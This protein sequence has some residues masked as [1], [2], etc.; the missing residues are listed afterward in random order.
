MQA[1]TSFRLLL[2]FLW[3]A[4]LAG[5]GETPERPSV[6]TGVAAE[7]ARAA[8]LA[9]AGQHLAAADLYRQLAA[10]TQT[11]QQRADFLLA[12]AEASRAGGDWDGTRSTLEQLAQMGLGGRQE[13]ER[14]MLQAEVLLQERRPGD[15]LATLG[16]PPAPGTPVDLQ[17]RYHQDVAAAYR[18]MG[19]LLET[20][21][22]LQ[23]VDALQT[24]P[25]QRLETQTEI[26]RTLALLNELVLSN[27]Q[28][29]P[30]DIG[31]GWM[32]LALLVKKYGSDPDEL[33]PLLAEWRQ[34][35]PQHPA[36]PALLD[37]YQQ[38]LQRQLQH[39]ARIGVLLP[40]SG[41]YAEVAA[42]I[43]DGIVISRFQ[44]APERRPALK[45]YDA[46]DPAGIWPLYNQAVADGAELVI[47]P[48]Q[49]EA[50]AQLVRAGELP[51]PVLAL[52]QVDAGGAPPA[53]LYMYSLSPEDEARQA[54]ERAWTDGSRR[55]VI[56]APQG[57]WGD[58]LV[59]AFEARWRSLG[60]SIAGTGRYDESSH[61]HSDTIMQLLHIDQSIARY[62]QLQSWLG[63]NLEFEP[64]RRA[65]VDAVFMAARPVQAQGM[66][67][68]LQFHRAGDL[69]VYATS[70]SWQGTLTANQVEDMKGIMLADIPWLLS[71]STGDSYDRATIAGY[72]PRSGSAYARLY[73]MGMDA[74]RLVPHL[75]RLQSSRYESLDGSTGNLYMDETNQIHRQLVW[76]LLD[77]QLQILG[78]SPRLDLQGG[79]AE[80]APTTPE[81][82]PGTAPPSPAS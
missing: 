9:A 74:L 2:L 51:V 62:R 31:G 35:F 47:G 68:Q 8:N 65:D 21:N 63:R 54:A 42:A 26:L 70:A 80:T 4:L 52:N 71:N 61:D 19:N 67:P 39:V 59:D 20:A 33:A 32:Q 76:V 38:Y 66:R 10:Q 27:L 14:R 78:Y 1:A 36:L 28:P 23:A 6:P 40:Q 60:G 16:P 82:A 30:P 79:G 58:R 13:L 49:K 77:E 57:N 43:R 22:A 24:D 48:L 41:T 46:T 15:A 55:P 7:A 3:L 50:V 5:C 12:A 81:T 44:L 73:A 11:P 64:R 25:Q 75:R 53:N 18:L 37:N 56:L 34:R 17:I 45:F 72:L 69:P 29:P